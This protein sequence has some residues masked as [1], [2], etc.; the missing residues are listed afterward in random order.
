M[1]IKTC[2]REAKESGYWVR[3]LQCD[4]ELEAE[5]AKLLTEAR[6]LTNVFGAI[7]RKSEE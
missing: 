3:L 1:K 6:E 4:G 2:R 5:R 7:V